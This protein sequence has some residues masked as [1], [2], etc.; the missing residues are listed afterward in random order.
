VRAPIVILGLPRTGTT[1]LHN[2]MSQ[3]PARCSPGGLRQ[4][5]TPIAPAAADPRSCALRRGSAVTGRCRSSRC[6]RWSPRRATRRSSCWRSPSRRCSSR[7]A[8]SSRATAT[9]TGRR[10]R[11]PPISN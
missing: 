1:H 8:T 5:P 9:G 2:L 7:R 6:T 4:S 3:D 11:R 10:I